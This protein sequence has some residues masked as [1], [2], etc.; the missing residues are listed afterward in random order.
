L[1][2]AFGL[3]PLSPSLSRTSVVELPGFLC[4]AVRRGLA[5]QSFPRGIACSITVETH[6]RV[7]RPNSSGG[8]QPRG[9][10]F[11]PLARRCRADYRPRDEPAALIVSTAA[12]IS[13]TR[14]WIAPPGTVNTLSQPN[15]KNA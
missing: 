15:T 12:A 3:A 6:P 1:H 14:N 2:R 11:L 7:P 13:Q 8:R 5:L 4:A 10:V 9:G